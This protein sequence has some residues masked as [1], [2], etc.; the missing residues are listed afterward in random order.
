MKYD[1]FDFSGKN[2]PEFSLWQSGAWKNILAK[3]G[4]AR[5]V[6]Y[7]GNPD[8]TFFLVEIRSVGAGFFGAFIL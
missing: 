3:S 8:S 2:I 1:V 4:Q 7:F 5:E 6:F